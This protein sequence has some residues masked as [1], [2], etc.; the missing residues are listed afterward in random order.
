LE[1]YAFDNRENLRRVK[2]GMKNQL[3]SLLEI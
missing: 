1:Y 2:N 3:T